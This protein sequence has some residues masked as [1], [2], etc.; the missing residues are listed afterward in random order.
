MYVLLYPQVTNMF[1]FISAVIFISINL[2]TAATN[3]DEVLNL[4]GLTY[5]LNFHHYSGYLNASSGKY[6]HYWFVESQKN[7]SEDPL[8]LWLNG[9]PGCSSLDGLLSENG[10]FHVNPDGKTLYENV[11]SWNK[12]ANVLYLE[13]PAGVGFS[14]DDNQDYSTD[15][16]KVSEDNYLALQ[17]FFIKYPQ[18][19]KNDFYISGESY[20]GIYIPTLSMRVFTGPAKINFKGFAIGN[21][22]LDVSFLGNSLIFFGYYHG[23]FGKNLWNDLTSNCCNGGASQKN[24]NFVSGETAACSG[25][26]AKA[27]FIIQ[28]QG[29]NVYNLYSD[30]QHSSYKPSRDQIDRKLLFS[31]FMGNKNVILHDDPPCVDSSNLRKWLNQQSVREALHIPS[32]V[33]RWDICSLDVEIGYQRL[34]N[35][36]KPQVTKLINSGKL[37]GLIYNGDVD[38]AC[39]F[40][41]DQWFVDDLSFKVTSEYK[42]WEFNDQI[43]GY[44]KKFGNLTYMTIKGSGHMVPQ[45]KPGPAFK[46]ISSFLYQKPL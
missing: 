43:A 1:L 38:M 36:M 17:N 18:F 14:Y 12:I 22:Y 6:L 35:T 25:A 11:Y 30:C 16:D 9:G 40:L 13:A 37:R 28:G 27:T 31:T 45:D 21:G 3:P 32:N 23:L 44:Y 39:N 2:I 24:C 29:L 19:K 34:Y 42:Y 7:P 33:Q 26:V 10:P 4:P 41:G 20:G 8:V 15:D 46:M 5:K